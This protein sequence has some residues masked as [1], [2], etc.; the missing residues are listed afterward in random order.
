MKPGS[1]FGYARIDS[2]DDGLKLCAYDEHGNAVD[3]TEYQDSECSLDLSSVGRVTDL[4]TADE[5]LRVRTSLDGHFI[6]YQAAELDAD[7]TKP[8]SCCDWICFSM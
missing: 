7:R 1:Y 6:F 2:V 3:M 4:I 8:V 5:P